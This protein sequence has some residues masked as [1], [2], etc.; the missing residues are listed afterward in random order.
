MNQIQPYYDR[1]TRS[2]FTKLP[3]V[4]TIWRRKSKSKTKGTKLMYV[5]A[6]VDYDIVFV[7]SNPKA[8]TA[9]VRHT[10]EAWIKKD[11]KVAESH[12]YD[13]RFYNLENFKTTFV[14]AKV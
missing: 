7:S 8:T 12:K 13:G 6:V 11:G 10:N 4:G 5:I 3:K 9:R 2:I 1:Q 14:K